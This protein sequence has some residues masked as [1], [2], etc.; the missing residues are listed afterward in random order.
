MTITPLL[1]IIDNMN[2]QELKN[3]ID[4]IALNSDIK[5]EHI[6]VCIPNNKGGMGSISATK[7]KS[8]NRGFDWNSGLFIIW[9]EVEMVETQKNK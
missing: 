2:L 7:V 8:A 1:R 3:E 6:K 5:L 9:P 4:A